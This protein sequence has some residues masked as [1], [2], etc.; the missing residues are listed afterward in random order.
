MEGP[1]AILKHVN[2]SL[3]GPHLAY[4]AAISCSCWP[5]FRN[6]R[7]LRTSVKYIFMEPPETI[8]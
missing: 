3:Q 4:I 5:P 2:K 1:F 8:Y 6:L 7:N